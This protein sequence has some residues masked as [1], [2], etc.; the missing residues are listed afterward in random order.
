MDISVSCPASSIILHFF[1]LSPFV[2]F[3]FDMQ[4]MTSGLLMSYSHN[5][6]F[7][8]DKTD[9][10]EV[11]LGK[12]CR[13]VPSSESFTSSHMSQ[14]VVE[15]YKFFGTNFPSA[16]LLTTTHA[17]SGFLTGLPSNRTV[18]CGCISIL[19][20]LLNSHFF[21]AFFLQENLRV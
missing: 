15:L 1:F 6:C 3:L 20:H 2:E 18:A 19:P 10:L 11:T 4:R 8:D 14:I 9:S 21:L 7:T 17:L 13:D 16:V 12:N 5:I